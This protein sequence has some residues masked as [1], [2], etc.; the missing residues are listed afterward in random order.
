MSHSTDDSPSTAQDDQ[1]AGPDGARCKRLIETVEGSSES[2]PPAKRSASPEPKQET[3][4]ECIRRKC[5]EALAR[6][7]T[8]DEIERFKYDYA[9][10]YWRALDLL[11]DRDVPV[12]PGD[13]LDDEDVPKKHVKS[14]LNDVRAYIRDPSTTVPMLGFFVNPEIHEHCGRLL[15]GTQKWR[16]H[17]MLSLARGADCE[18]KIERLPEIARFFKEELGFPAADAKSERLSDIAYAM[19][20]PNWDSDAHNCSVAAGLYHDWTTMFD[21]Q[22]YFPRRAKGIMG[23]VN[24]LW[25]AITKGRLDRIQ[26]WAKVPDLVFPPSWRTIRDERTGET[27]DV[28]ELVDTRDPKKREAYKNAIDKLVPPPTQPEKVQTDLVAPEEIEPK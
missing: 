22:M 17:P 5:D 27:F 12:N 2:E 13:G 7:Y 20:N 23:R 14:D 4:L 24:V 1:I 3:L 19:C 10:H 28:L 26:S 6:E 9:K 11:K 8:E 18:P 15:E 25:W 16:Q 21:V